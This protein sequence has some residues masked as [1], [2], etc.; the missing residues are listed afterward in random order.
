MSQQVTRRHGEKYIVSPYKLLINDGNYYLLAYSDHFKDM[1]THRVDRTKGVKREGI[2][3]KGK[4]VLNVTLDG[5]AF[6]HNLIPFHVLFN[7]FQP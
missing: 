4:D 7:A 2:P 1:R 3:R 5:M 6:D